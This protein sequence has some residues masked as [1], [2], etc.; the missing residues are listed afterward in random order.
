MRRVETVRNNSRGRFVEKLDTDHSTD[1]RPRDDVRGDTKLSTQNG[2]SSQIF[3]TLVR[4]RWP[5]TPPRRPRRGLQGE[6]RFRQIS[7]RLAAIKPL[8]QTRLSAAP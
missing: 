3:F 5:T 7:S 6:D 4:I 8:R 2:F 1:P